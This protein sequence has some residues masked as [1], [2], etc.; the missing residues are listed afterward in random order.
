MKTL[1]LILFPFLLLA[2]PPMDRYQSP[3]F[4]SVTETNQVQF[5]T[6]VPQPKPGGGFWELISGLP[7]NVKEYDT[8]SENLY[9]DIF[10]PQGDTLSSRPLVIICYGGGFVTGSKD[11]WSIRLLCQDLAKHGYVTAAIDYRLG[12]YV[13]DAELSKRAA[14]RGVQDSRSAIRFFRADAAGAN[15]Y[16]IDSSNIYVGGHS[17][18]AFI[19]LHNAYLDKE[20]ERPGSTFD[21]T[22]VG[23]FVS[24]LGCL[25]CA[26]D[27][28]GFDGH[29]DAIF[30]LAGAVASVSYIESADDPKVVMFHSEDDDTVPYDSGQPFSNL[31]S[32][33]P[34]ADLPIVY[35]SEPISIRADLIGLANG[36]H[37][38]TNRGHGVHEDSNNTLYADIIPGITDWFYEQELKPIGDEITGNMTVCSSSLTETYTYVG[39]GYYYDWSVLGGTLSV[40]SPYSK[41]VEVIWNASAP[42]HVISVVPY[43]IQDAKGDAVVSTIQIQSSQDI[44]YLGVDV[45]WQSVANW[46]LGHI[47][48]QCEDV[49]ISAISGSGMLQ[50]NTTETINRLIISNTGGLEVLPNANLSIHRHEVNS[51]LPVADLKGFLLNNGNLNILKRDQ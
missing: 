41:E 28:Q 35:G 16:K 48:L 36:F 21:T 42:N 18:G 6:G 25:D 11:H 9:M 51:V 43:S 46:S 4:G 13:F 31:L 39:E 3:L 22:Q 45:D 5:S 32:L 50:I 8:T 40:S 30:S 14:Y 19:A 29:A 37:S 2:Q 12:M 33:V 24:D 15:I 34:G 44:T 23:N 27:N 38:Y 47:P 7:V 26:G 20:S 49:Y 10:Q 17:A 1:I